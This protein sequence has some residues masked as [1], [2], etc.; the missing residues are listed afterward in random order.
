MADTPSHPVLNP[1]LHLNKDPRPMSINGGGKERRLIKSDRLEKQRSVLGNQ[2]SELA[3]TCRSHP[4]FNQ[5]VILYA[6]MFSDSL[7]QYVCPT[8][9]FSPL[10]GAQLITPYKNGYLVELGLKDLKAFSSLISGAHDIKTQV[11]ISRLCSVAFFGVEHL[12]SPFSQCSQLW[13]SAPELGRGRLFTVWLMPFHDGKAAEELL[14]SFA[15]LQNVYI[16]S[17][18]SSLQNFTKAVISR[19]VPEKISKDTQFLIKE[20]DRINRAIED[21]KKNKHART[22]VLVP[23][24]VALNKLITSG[25][26]YRIDPKPSIITTASGDGPE[27]ESPLKDQLEDS[28][29]VGIVDG[30]LTAKSYFSAV[31]WRSPFLIE[32]TLA[33][34]RHGNKITS[35]IVNGYAWNNNL[36]LPKLNCRVGIVQAIP[37]KD[38]A[39][40]LD[41]SDLYQYLNEI[42]KTHPET[43]V[44]N[45]SFNFKYSCG[46]DHVSPEGHDLAKIARRHNVLFVISGGNTPGTDIQPPADCE[47]AISVGGCQHDEKGAAKGHCP[48]CLGGPGPANMLKPEVSHFSE[49]RVL[50]GNIVKGSS[51]AAALTSVLATHTMKQLRNPSPDLV[52]ALIIH[53][54]NGECFDP[55]VGF[56]APTEYL[57]WLCRPGFVTLQWTAELRPGANFYWELP[58]PPS[59]TKTGLLKGIAELTTILNPQPFVSDYADVNYFSARL[60]SALQ[61]ASANGKYYNLIGHSETDKMTEEQAREF[62]HKWSP[63]KHNKKEF[64]KKYSGNSL[65]VYA[66]IFTRDLYSYGYR[67]SSEIPPLKATFVLS[68]GSDDINDDIYNETRALLGSSVENSTVD[69]DINININL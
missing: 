56:G 2:F 28:P 43:K 31:S 67:T 61:Y 5:K 20:D 58:I 11:D 15:D 13:E 1:V 22:S 16:S 37:K 6:E 32:D 23:N 57:P 25:T 50:G 17:P 29:V 35:L 38:S 36:V 8:D 46:L 64:S 3:N 24:P 39:V 48:Y 19:D 18:P 66:R 34:V 54:T 7:A 42:V 65:R 30:G 53:N 51:Y 49:V 27:P 47:A 33:D 52:K 44:W 40:H 60:Q 45:L 59:L 63:V 68:L 41:G 69:N 26:V 55:D 14:T 12:I 62:D 9:L 10:N 4:S 21:Y